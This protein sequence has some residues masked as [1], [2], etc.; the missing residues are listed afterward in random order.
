MKIVLLCREENRKQIERE[1]DS[2][3]FEPPGKKGDL[4]LVEEG[5]EAPPGAI[6]ITFPL[7]RLIEVD[8]MVRNMFPASKIV[9]NPGVI[10]V[11]EDESI[12][13]LRA[14]DILYFY[15]RKGKLFC[16]LPDTHYEVNRTLYEVEVQL[17]DRGFIRISKTH[18]VN[19]MQIREVLPW[20][21]GGAVLKFNNFRGELEV[22]R[23]YKAHFRDYINV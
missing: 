22:S 6:A 3:T 17:F 21:G 10:S 7:S 14:R 1:F 23:R 9:K 2:V 20:F 18:V 5:M 4:Y 8:E 15:T 12:K 19:I 11:R 13:V 16:Q